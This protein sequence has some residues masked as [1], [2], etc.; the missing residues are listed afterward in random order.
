V[1]PPSCQAS[2]EKPSLVVALVCARVVAAYDRRWLAR[3]VSDLIPDGGP[4]PERL[5]R[6]KARLLAPL[7][8]LVAS[9][10]RRGRPPRQEASPEVRR[11]PLCAALLTVATE[12]LAELR[13]PVRRRDLQD[14]LVCAYD[15]LH[16]EHGATVE[17]FCAA[18]AIPE[19]TFR[20]WRHRPSRPSP[21]PRPPPAPPPRR[22]DRE[23][24][25]FALDTTAPET[26]LG[27]DTT[28]LSVLGVPLKLIAV[29]DLG[30]REQRLFEAFHLDERETAALVERV[31]DDAV[32]GRGGLQFITDQGTPYLA[33][34]AREA[35]DAR[36]VEH[37]PQKEA[38]PTEKATVERAFHTVKQALTPLLA[39]T[40]RLAAS[41]PQLRRTDLARHLGTLLLAVFLRVYQAGRRHV[42]HPLAAADPD[43]L[44]L[45]VAEQ[46]E[47]ARAED[48]S[49][50]LFLEAIHAEYAMPGSREAFVRAFRRYPLDDL[51]DAERRFRAYACRCQTRVCDRYFAAVLRDVHE[52]GRRRRAGERAQARAAADARR[53]R[54]EVLRLAAHLDAHPGE[55]IVESLDVLAAAWCPDEERFHLD[56][57]IGRIPLRRALRHL[58]QRSTILRDTVETHVRGWITLR[59]PPMSLC[60]AV[61]RVIAQ[62]ITHL[63]DRNAT[64]FAS[65]L[66]GATMPPS[67]DRSTDKQRPPPSPHLRI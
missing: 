7:E 30:A 3:P 56:A 10:M 29:Q 32:A 49:V 46:R 63:P 47:R 19:R 36:A 23:T 40:D 5:S 20:S 17:E 6:L 37:A 65:L 38:T 52:R 60:D 27:G 22:N 53:K 59:R 58:H 67:A 26:Q 9:A 57:A 64:P 48:R 50:R 16:R 18:L 24:G 44:R 35:Y 12:L 1:S 51:H 21:P 39:L 11:A 54:E 62:E 34:A 41:V 28:D 8:T 66:V 2:R 61:R 33:E 4:G 13:V 45:V 43:A 42:P 14:R 15:R 31:V 25:R 55:A